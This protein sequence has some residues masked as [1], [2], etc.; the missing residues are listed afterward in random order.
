[1]APIV[2]LISRLVDRKGLDLIIAAMDRLMSLD[3]KLVIL[4]TGEEKYHV[5]LKDMA[6]AYPGRIGLKFMYQRA[7][8][9][10]V[11]A[12]ADIFLMPSRYE[13]CGLEQLY[14]LKYGTIPVV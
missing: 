10:K 6:A 5:S 11:M 3:L 12:G 1:D 2:A 8:A 13:P 9:H 4:G 14:G 7:L